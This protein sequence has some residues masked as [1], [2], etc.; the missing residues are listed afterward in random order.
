M[1][2]SRQNIAEQIIR[3]R[4]VAIVRLHKQSDLVKAIKCLV[5]GGVNVLEITSNTLGYLDE[6]SRARSD[7]SQQLIGAGTVTNGSIAQDAIAAGAQFLVTPNVSKSVVEVAHKYEV[8]VLMGAMTPTEIVN[9][10]EIE[11]DII[12]LFPAAQLGIEYCKSLSGPF[13][14]IPLFAVGGIHMENV[15]S[16]LK[17]AVTG[18]GVGNQLTRAVKGEKEILKH[19]AYVR[20]FIARVKEVVC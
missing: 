3:Q 13:N 1:L 8:P 7:Y 19:T 5:N 14:D 2:S 9:A 4:L 12:K 10:I 6:I 15:S 20:R 17:S 11:A 16:W 18:V